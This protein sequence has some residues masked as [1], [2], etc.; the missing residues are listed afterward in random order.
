MREVTF[1][2]R[3]QQRWKEFEQM[4]EAPD[5]V[6][7]TTLSDAYVQIMDDLAFAR[8]QYP[9]AKTTEYLNAVST[10]LH[11]T[12]T[13][14]KRLRADKVR[15]LFFYEIPLAFVQL[16]MH[17]LIAAG[18]FLTCAVI[19]YLSA[20]NNEDF[21]RTVLGYG[22]VEMTIENIKSGQPLDVYN[23]SEPW[24]MFLHIAY[25]NI[26]ILL[27]TV[28]FGLLPVV[29]AAYLLIPNGVMVGTFM[30]LFA[31]YNQL[32]TATLGIWI[33]GTLEISAIVIGC[34]AAIRVTEAVL[35]P[36]TYPRMEA[37]VRGVRQ[38][39]LVAI[40]M[41][42]LLL[43]AALLEG[44]VTRFYATSALLNLSIILAS[45]A[46]VVWYVVIWPGILVRRS[47]G[48]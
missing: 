10:R 8:A 14:N 15:S 41:V 23:Q 34:G 18:V 5:S 4:L 16:R 9:N 13:R 47:H 32:P 24:R 48:V 45:A 31:K 25:N 21:A 17:M 11:S 20:V 39:V 43:V 37:F 28:G 1:I 27:R 7:A 6:N 30:G 36:H 19:G 29:G 40:G 2:R 12:L 22:Y 26:M 33:H 46:F 42:P 35:H 38:A 3:N 44:Y